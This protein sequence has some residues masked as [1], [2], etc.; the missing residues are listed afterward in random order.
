MSRLDELKAQV[1]SRKYQNY[2]TP[3]SFS[4][5][6]MVWTLCLLAVE[7]IDLRFLASL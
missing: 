1:L 5:I 6:V 3:R 2:N 7:L 4:V